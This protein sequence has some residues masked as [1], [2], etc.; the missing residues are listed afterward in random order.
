MPNTGQQR[1]AALGPRLTRNR[2]DKPAKRPDFA[3]SRKKTA[4][5]GRPARPTP[6]LPTRHPTSNTHPPTTCA[7][8]AQRHHNASP[9]HSCTRCRG[10]CDERKYKFLL[11]TC[12]PNS[13]QTALHSPSS[14]QRMCFDGAQ[15]R[16]FFLHFGPSFL[17]GLLRISYMYERLGAQFLE[18]K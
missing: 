14:P 6:T 13:F 8:A 15:R 11:F 5:P 9:R 12:K 16:R 17:A 7:L 2:P 4:Q 3:G 10:L 18:V 1:G